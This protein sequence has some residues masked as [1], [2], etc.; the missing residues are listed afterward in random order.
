MLTLTD[1]VAQ[2]LT[3]RTEVRAQLDRVSSKALTAQV[4]D[5]RAQLDHLI[6]PSFITETGYRQLQHVP[7]YLKGAAVRLDRLSQGRPWRR[8]PQI[9]RRSRSLRMSTT[10]RLRPCR[11][12]CR[13]RRA[14]RG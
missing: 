9:C 8:T 13:C 7:R 10:R 12:S 4:S 6:H 5:M 2:A 14:L 1:A 3:L 11:P